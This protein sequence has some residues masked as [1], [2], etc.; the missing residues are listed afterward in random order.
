LRHRLVIIRFAMLGAW[1][2]DWV[3]YLVSHL[4][5]RVSR[6]SKAYMLNT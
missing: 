2:G 6:F 3:A 1:E 4:S 5:Y